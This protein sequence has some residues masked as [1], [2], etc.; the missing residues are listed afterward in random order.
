M[1]SEFS[2][3]GKN[4]SLPQSN[5]NGCLLCLSLQ[6]FSPIFL[7]HFNDLSDEIPF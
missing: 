1:G 4:I 6:R 7:L 3:F 5:M 2:V